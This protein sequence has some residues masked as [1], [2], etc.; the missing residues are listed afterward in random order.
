MSN[1]FTYEVKKKYGTVSENGN[2][3]TEVR[4]ISYNGKSPKYDI[5]G[6]KK[7]ET[8]EVMCKGVTL[9]KDELLSLRNL[10]VDIGESL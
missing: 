1:E 10:L 2:Y 5:R 6:W 9:T 7:T 3:T 8:G 4:L